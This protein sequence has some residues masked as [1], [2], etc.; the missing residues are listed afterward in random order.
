VAIVVDAV[1][2]QARV[3]RRQAIGPASHLSTIQF[4]AD[5]GTG[6]PHQTD[7]NRE[8]VLAIRGTGSIV[9]CLECDGSG[10]VTCYGCH[11]SARQ[12][13]FGCNGRGTTGTPPTNCGHCSGAGFVQC[14]TCNGKGHHQHVD[15][16]GEGRLGRWTEV[17]YIPSK[18]HVRQTFLPKSPFGEGITD[19]ALAWL[20]PSGDKS[21]EELTPE[22]VVEKLGYDCEDLSALIATAR[23]F[24]VR[25]KERSREAGYRCHAVTCRY[26]IVPVRAYSCGTILG[27]TETVWVVGR[28]EAAREARATDQTSRMAASVTLHSGLLGVVLSA[29]LF[30]L[31][32]R[33]FPAAGRL[34]GALVLQLSVGF[35]L[36]ALSLSRLVE[37]TLKRSRAIRGMARVM[38]VVQ[39]NL[40][41][42]GKQRRVR[43]VAVVSP[44]DEARTYLACV[45]LVG[46]H[47]SR[48]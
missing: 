38:D 12:T 26:W 28:G 19:A 16:G 30:M 9:L 15:C 14:L 17:A 1:V 23:N 34:M 4:Y 2:E 37:A 41:R 40:K 21:V 29:G 25:L 46:S 24:D 43:T 10:Q 31:A 11:G 32:L 36:G 35:A 44:G 48:L 22:R 18:E 8:V 7:G 13:C 42:L 5:P 6:W 27:C 33:Y 47:V 39:L 20:L 45:A 3:V